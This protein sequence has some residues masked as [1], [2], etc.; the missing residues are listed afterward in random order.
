MP[1][2]LTVNASGRN[3]AYDTGL[4]ESPWLQQFG[5]NLSL[6]VRIQQLAEIALK[7]T[8]NVNRREPKLKIT[9]LAMAF[10]RASSDVAKLIL[11]HPDIDV[12]LKTPLTGTTS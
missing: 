4:P 6:G 11:Q 9:A 3:I 12:S 1:Q 5:A 10:E 7:A 8:N 2:A